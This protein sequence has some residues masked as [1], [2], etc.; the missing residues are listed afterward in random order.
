MLQTDLPT[1]NWAQ[2]LRW[3]N[4]HVLIT[5]Q[6]GQKFPLVF[7]YPHNEWKNADNLECKYNIYVY[8]YGVKDG[9]LD[10]SLRSV[11][12]RLNVING[13][14]LLSLCAVFLLG[15]LWFWIIITFTM[16]L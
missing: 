14:S 4:T 1:P 13:E 11:V 6:N 16:A 2:Y 8:V 15:L 12:S 9:I 3:V 10:S 7:T 5:S